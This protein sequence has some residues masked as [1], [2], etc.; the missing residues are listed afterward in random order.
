MYARSYDRSLIFKEMYITLPML[1]LIS[2]KARGHND[3]WK[4]SKPCHV[5]IH[6]K[7]HT[8]YCQLIVLFT[9]AT[10]IRCLDK[11]AAT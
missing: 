2:S 11:A 3:F 8:E 7:A 6:W 10:G 1:R 4:P 9:S 5:G